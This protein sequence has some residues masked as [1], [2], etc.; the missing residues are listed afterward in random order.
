MTLPHSARPAARRLDVDGQAPA[1]AR[2]SSA[3]HAA[4]KSALQQHQQLPLILSWLLQVQLKIVP[5][6]SHGFLHMPIGAALRGEPRCLRRGFPLLPTLLPVIASCSWRSS[7]A[8]LQMGRPTGAASSRFTP[9]A[10][11]VKRRLRTSR[12]Q[13]CSRPSQATSRVTSHPRRGADATRLQRITQPVSDECELGIRATYGVRGRAASSWCKRIAARLCREIERG[14]RE[15]C[16][17]KA[18]RAA[19]VAYTP[20]YQFL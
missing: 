8:R 11:S 3:L 7:G 17:W 18:A 20:R 6:S 15:Q 10:H 16:R 13:A 1:L 9:C 5:E 14:R 2:S 4:F 12:Q 19:Q